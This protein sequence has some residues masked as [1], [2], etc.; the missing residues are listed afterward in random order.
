MRHFGDA[1]RLDFRVVGNLASGPLRRLMLVEFSTKGMPEEMPPAAL[2]WVPRWKDG[3]HIVTLA[4][5]TGH[6]RRQRETD[7][8]M[9][10][11]NIRAVAKNPGAPPADAPCDA[12]PP[13][14]CAEWIPH[15]TTAPW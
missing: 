12:Q 9:I 13:P 8:E 1:R 2:V 14:S 6:A 5:L 15:P 7:T 11:Q 3:M 4:L 10:R